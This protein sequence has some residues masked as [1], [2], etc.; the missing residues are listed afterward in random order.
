MANLAAMA[1]SLKKFDNVSEILDPE[2]PHIGTNSAVLSVIEPELWRFEDLV[3]MATSL[4]NFDN[5]FEILDPENPHIDTNSAVISV[6]EPELCEFEVPIWLPW[7][8]PF[9]WVDRHQKLIDSSLAN[10]QPSL[11]I[12]CKSVQNCE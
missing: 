12:S 9:P 11:K 10:C 5:A 2:N 7:Q 6:I 1:T 3:A 4:K 8:R